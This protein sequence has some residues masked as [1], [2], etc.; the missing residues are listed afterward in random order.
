MT[1][2]LD[3]ALTGTTVAVAATT[4]ISLTTV[5]CWKQNVSLMKHYAAEPEKIAVPV[6]SAAVC[7][8]PTETGIANR[9][10]SALQAFFYI[11]VWKGVSIP[12]K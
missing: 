8:M 2:A 12:A 4:M 6:N 11:A 7:A 1:D 10:R 3:A 5:H 9:E